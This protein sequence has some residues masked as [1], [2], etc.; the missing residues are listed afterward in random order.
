MNGL[1]ILLDLSFY[2]FWSHTVVVVCERHGAVAEQ[3]L[4]ESMKP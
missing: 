3:V 4:E 1:K 2:N